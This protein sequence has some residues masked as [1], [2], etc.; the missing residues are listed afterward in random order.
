MEFVGWIVFGL[1]AGVIANMID[2]GKTRGGLVGTVILGVLGAIVGGF[3]ANIIFGVGI[4]SFSLISFII[5]VIGAI[6]L[7]FVGRS[8]ERP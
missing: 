7:L 6:A 1:M 4:T 2:P 8:L 3:L 5:A